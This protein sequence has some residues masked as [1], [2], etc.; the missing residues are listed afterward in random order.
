MR[1]EFSP[2]A[3][4]DL[5]EIAEYIGREDPSRAATFV[6]ALRGRC[7][8]IARQPKGN[9]LRAELGQG[10]R[11]C[12]FRS[13]LIFYR[14]LDDAVRVERILHAAR[15]VMGIVASGGFNG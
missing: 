13:Y 5:T 12:P 7:N 11:V 9:P 6:A 10:V 2:A 14:V 15:D 3:V 1:R 8:T 4:G